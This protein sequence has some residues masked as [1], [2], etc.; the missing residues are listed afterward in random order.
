[1][2][3]LRAKAEAA[4]SSE[5]SP[6]W[7]GQAGPLGQAMPAGALTARLADEALERLRSLLR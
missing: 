3:P 7:T 5:F 6:L 4:G 2:T 1:V